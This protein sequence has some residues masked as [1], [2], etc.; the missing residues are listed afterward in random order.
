[1]EKVPQKFIF[2]LLS[3]KIKFLV[4]GGHSAYVAKLFFPYIL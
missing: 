3:I 4:L 2:T 1:M